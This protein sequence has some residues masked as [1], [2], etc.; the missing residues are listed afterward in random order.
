MMIM[1]LLLIG[2]VVVG[3]VELWLW[4][5]H[6]WQK[7]L[8]YLCTMIAAATLS[9][10]VMSSWHLPVPQPLEMLVKWVKQLWQGG[11]LL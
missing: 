3:A 9:I 1:I 4:P 11:G 8:A 7:V 6:P 2:Y 10:L 5:E